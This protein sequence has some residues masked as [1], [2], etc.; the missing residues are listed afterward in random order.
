MA[1]DN[2]V[3]S[4]EA[5][6][7]EDDVETKEEDVVDAEEEEDDG[8]IPLPE[9]ATPMMIEDMNAEKYGLKTG[10]KIKDTV[11]YKLVPYEFVMEDLKWGINSSFHF[12][13][14]VD[15][16]ERSWAQTY[17]EGEEFL[18]VAD[19][20][21][22]YGDGWIFATTPEGKEAL[23]D[24]VLAEERALQAAE[25]ARLDAIAKK[26]AEEAAIRNAVYEEVPLRVQPYESQTEADTVSEVDLFVERAER[27]LLKYRLV[28]KRRF[29]GGPLSFADDDAEHNGVKEFRQ[30]KDPNFDLQ[31]AVHDTGLQIGPVMRF[32]RSVETQTNQQRSVNRSTQYE[33]MTLTEDRADAICEQPA[34]LKFMEDACYQC[35]VALQ[36]NE[37]IDVFQMELKQETGSNNDDDDLL[38]AQ[39]SETDVTKLRSLTHLI[40]S[41]GKSLPSLDWH[42]QKTG[43]IVACSEENISFNERSELAGTAQ[44]GGGKRLD[45]SVQTDLHDWLR[46]LPLSVP[47]FGG[48]WTNGAM[49]DKKL[50]V[51][52][53]FSSTQQLLDKIV[54]GGLALQQVQA[55]ASEGIL[56]ATIA[57]TPVVILVHGKIGA[58]T[59]LTI[60]SQVPA[61]NERIAALVQEALQS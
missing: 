4:T 47:E 19:V 9:G 22:V 14:G 7:T 33:P 45:F 17:P 36:Q 10:P 23:L 15:G 55:R 2:K 56:S 34:F 16:K 40:Y 31:M 49:R 37:T 26:E 46:P 57:G 51:A 44:Y 39:A 59:A 3:A 54:S 6:A 28:R 42:P 38:G 24:I 41:K 50:T 48:K 18:L 25:Q 35:E 27:P 1:D 12:V 13:K 21:D 5:K 60:K 20:D 61:L 29:F 32:N 30:H 8:P 53:G 11:K 58:S 43:T 52:A